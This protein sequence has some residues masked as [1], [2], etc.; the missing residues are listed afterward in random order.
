M[1]GR[2]VGGGWEEERGG[3]EGR[4]GWMWSMG[5]KGKRQKLLLKTH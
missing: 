3:G 5:M 2:E 4:I 1:A